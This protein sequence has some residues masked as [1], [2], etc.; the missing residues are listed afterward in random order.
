MRAFQIEQCP[1]DEGDYLYKK[2]EIE[3]KPGLT[4]LVGCNG[5]GKTTLLQTINNQLRD[6][7]DIA[8]LHYS[9]LSKGGQAAKDKAGFNDNFELLA[10]LLCSSEGEQVVI[11]LGQTSRQIGGFVKKHHEECKEI[12]VLLDAIDSGLSID[13]IVDIKEYL[14]KTMLKSFETKDCELYLVVVANSYEMCSEANCFDVTTG[15]YIKFQ[16]YPEYKEFIL[17]SKKYKD[18]RYDNS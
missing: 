18:T 7:P 6:I 3:I 17:N 14:F 16:S 11:N 15:E 10:T 8:V 1:F 13:N 5:S 12:W 9:N 2:D 4:V